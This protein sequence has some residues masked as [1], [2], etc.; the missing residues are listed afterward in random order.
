MAELPAVTW[1]Y[2]T[3]TNNGGFDL[4]FSRLTR[5]YTLWSANESLCCFASVLYLDIMALI[6]WIRLVSKSERGRLCFLASVGDVSV[7]I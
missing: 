4:L 1:N 5:G 2:L 7:S 6:R 3:E